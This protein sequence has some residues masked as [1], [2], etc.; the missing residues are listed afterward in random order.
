MNQSEK[1]KHDT[2]FGFLWRFLQSGSTQLINFIVSI[3]IARILSPAEYGIVA[4]TTVFVSFASIFVQYGFASSVIQR[5]GVSEEELSSVFFLGVVVSLILYIIL[6]LAAPYV[7]QF[8]QLRELTLILRVQS[9]S[10][11]L[12]SLFSIH[13]ALVNRE[14]KFKFSFIANFYSSAIRGVIGITLAISGF[15]VWAL[16]ISNLASYLVSLITFWIIVRWRPKFIFNLKAALEIFAFSSKILLSSLL[17]SIYGSLRSLIIGKKYNETGLAY[18]DRGS[19]FPMLIMSSVDGAMTQVMFASLSRLQKENSTF[20]NVLR[21]SMKISFYICAPIMFGMIVAAKP[22]VLSLLGEKWKGSI[23]FVRIMALNCMLW[24]LAAKVQAINAIGKSNITFIINLVEI[25]V[26]LICILAATIVGDIYAIA[27]S[28]IIST[29]VSMALTMI[30]CEKLLGYK[31]TT[32]ITDVLP[33]L[34]LAGIMSAVVYVES[35]I[36]IGNMLKLIVQIITGLIVYIAASAISR[37][38]SFKYLCTLA[39]RKSKKSNL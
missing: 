23:P 20:L 3:I 2:L 7:S 5:E 34:I 14:L 17:N 18:Y 37:N 36:P 27:F 38:E 11:V 10:L 30:F 21:R 32:Q 19:K 26:A 31:I 24:P 1:I 28:T 6:F 4:I 12:S 29:V 33:T 25:S 8:Y 22:M 39:R 15:G 16:V 35:F 9:L 13:Q